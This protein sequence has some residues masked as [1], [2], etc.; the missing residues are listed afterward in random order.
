[1]RPDY[2]GR[3]LGKTIVDG[4]VKACPGCSFILYA[5]P[6]KEP[7]YEKEHFRKMKTGMAL[8][9]DAEKMKAKGFIE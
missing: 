6:G 4:L 8:F 9:A 3:G 7:F 5:A 2:Q 1:V